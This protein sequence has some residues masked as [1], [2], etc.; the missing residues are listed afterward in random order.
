MYVGG[1]GVETNVKQGVKMLQQAA[2]E[3]S[4]EASWTLGGVLEKGDPAN[5]IEKD[6][7]KAVRLYKRAA[8]DTSFAGFTTLSHFL[9]TLRVT[10]VIPSLCHFWSTALS[11]QPL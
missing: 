5:D 7:P 1:Q 6:L 11:F 4:S 2:N 8:G 9:F 10:S 3:G